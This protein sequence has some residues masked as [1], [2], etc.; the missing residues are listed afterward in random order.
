MNISALTTNNRKSQKKDN[1]QSPN[2]NQIAGASVLAKLNDARPGQAKG[3]NVVKYRR[4]P[5]PRCAFTG[6]SSQ[7]AYI[8]RVA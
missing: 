6:H 1:K 2:G 8:R 4:C 3:S 5:L 7:G